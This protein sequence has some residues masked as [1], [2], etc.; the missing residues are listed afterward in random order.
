MTD[1]WRERTRRLGLPP[2]AAEAAAQRFASASRRFA[3]RFPDSGAPRAW[4]VPGRIEVLGKH[5][6]YGGGRSLLATVS[7]GFHWLAAPSTDGMVEVLDADTGAS[8]SIPLRADA[9]QRPADW[10][11]YLVSV[12][13]RVARDFPG[14]TTGM[15]AVFHSSLPRAAGLSS[16]S[17]LVIATFLPLAEFNRLEEHPAWRREIPDRMALAG[18]LGAVENGRAF[19]SFP[20]DHGVGTQGGSEDHTAILCCRARHLSIYRFL[21][22][23]HEGDVSLPDEWAFAIGVTGVHAPKSGAVRDHYNRLSAEVARLTALWQEAAGSDEPSLLAALESSPAAPD[24]LR[25]VV[26]ETPD[27]DTLLPRLGQFLAE[28]G[29][30]VPG[31]VGALRRGEVVG[32]GSLIER[33]QH[34]AEQVLRNQIP[35][36]IHLVRSARALGATAA[37]AFGAGFGGAVWALVRREELPAFLARWEEQY[38]AEY[39]GPAASADFFGTS[40][41]PAATEI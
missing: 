21:P 41:G 17:A 28:S 30:I 35:E 23:A 22:V 18:Y 36:T 27:A 6:D 16:S 12:V 4:W 3:E 31:V 33:S 39:P 1:P 10:S 2:D 38:R 5:T 40:P 11:D 37:S 20:I 34:L 29:E 19:G 25:A 8:C 32:I 9:P 24:R 13:R 14:A 7:R 15:R 26:R